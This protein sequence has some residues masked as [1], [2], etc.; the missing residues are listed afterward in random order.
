MNKEDYYSV[1]EVAEIYGVTKVTIRNWIKGGL[2]YKKE[3]VIGVI[4]N[5]QIWILGG[6][7]AF[8]FLA[9]VGLIIII[10]ILVQHR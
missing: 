1:S 8:G 9:I 4:T 7:V 3:K 5:R 2:S 10:T 6:L